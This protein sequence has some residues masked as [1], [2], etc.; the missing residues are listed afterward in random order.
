MTGVRKGIE[1]SNKLLMPLL[2]LVLILL[3]I[4]GL[5]ME[6]A[7]QG[8][9]FLFSPDWKALTPM[10][11]LVA[12][13]QAFFTLSI[14]QGTMI[15]YGSYLGKKE[16]VI[17]SCLPVVLMDT[18]VAFLSAIAVF[19]IVFSGGLKPD[20]GPA[21][22]FH[23][24]PWVFSKIPGGY[25]VAV[26]FFLLVFM[27]ALTSEISAL[28]PSIAYLIDEWKWKRKYA[29]VVCGLGAFLIGIP[30][31]L[32][33]SLLKEHLVFGF[34]FL[35]FMD[36]TTT[37]ILI[38]LGGLFAVLL[39]GWFWGVKKAVAQLK[40]GGEE[41]FKSHRWLPRYLS[42]SLKYSAPIL[43]LFVLFHALFL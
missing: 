35:D 13:G 10:A 38:P 1:F 11:F 33:S 37:G 19:T 21:L 34:T 41:T 20:A 22:I 2:F 30:C 27:A 3:V 40:E 7:S 12:L 18:L 42:F 28:E 15:T 6:N 43:I 14:G 8:L 25:F 9:T 36:F 29:V 5:T 26:L 4:K 24:L 17:T 31:A 32:S 39:V 16:N 23:T